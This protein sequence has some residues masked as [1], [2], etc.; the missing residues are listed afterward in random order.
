MLI[1]TPLLLSIS[2]S[3]TFFFS[4][5]CSYTLVYMS[6][7]SAKASLLLAHFKNLL[8]LALFFPLRVLPVLPAFPL[9]P[10]LPA[11]PV[12][13]VEAAGASVCWTAKQPPN[14]PATAALRHL[15]VQMLPV[16]AVGCLLVTCYSREQLRIHTTSARKIIW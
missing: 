7:E 6:P 11:L 4:G 8:L 1:Y 10:V 12:L 3:G 9:L 14:G 13:P 16:E 15:T 5:P 2:T